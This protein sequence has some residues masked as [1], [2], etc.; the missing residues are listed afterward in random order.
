MV[1]YQVF[2]SLAFEVANRKGVTYDGIA[3]GGD[4]IQQIAAYWQENKAE[5]K[6]MTELQAERRL[7]EIVEP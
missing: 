1:S 6:Q 3:D 5:L 7:Q 4:F 2:T